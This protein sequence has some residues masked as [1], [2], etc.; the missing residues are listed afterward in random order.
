MADIRDFE[1]LWG[2]WRSTKLLRQGAYGKV[3]LMEKVELGQRYYAAV[4]H[5]SIPDASGKSETLDAG[6]L[7]G[8]DVSLN[9]YY[10]Q[11]VDNH[12]TEINLNYRLKSNNIAS[13]DAHQ[14]ISREQEPGFDI[15][16]KMEFLT[17][18]KSYTMSHAM[19]VR[20]VARLGEDIS[21]ALTVVQQEKVHHWGI[22]QDD[23]FVSKDGVYKL[24]DIGGDK[25]AKGASSFISPE[26]ARGEEGG[27]CAGLYSLGLILYRLMNNNRGPFLPQ[28]AI[29]VTDKMN[30]SAHKRRMEGEALPP[31]ALADE[32]MGRIIL[33][34]CAYE[35][36]DRW[37]SAEQLRDA[38]I[39]YRQSLS[40]EAADAVVLESK[41]KGNATNSTTIALDTEETSVSE[42][43]VSKP[44]SHVEEVEVCVPDDDTIFSA[45]IEEVTAPVLD[46]DTVYSTPIEKVAVSLPAIDTTYSMSADKPTVALPVQ[47]TISQPS[48]VVT[49]SMLRKELATQKPIVEKK[50]KKLWVPIL[51]AVCAL[52]V[53]VVLVLS[54]YTS[55]GGAQ[56]ENVAVSKSPLAARPSVTIRAWQDPV[57][58]AGVR[59]ALGV[60]EGKL[61]PKALAGLEELNLSDS[62]EPISTLMDLAMLPGL[63]RLDLSG[64][65]VKQFDFPDEMAQLTSLNLTG[66]G[67]T[68]LEFMKNPILQGIINLAL[69]NNQV[70]DL[71]P[72]AGLTQL[73]YLNISDTSVLDLT[74][75]SGLPQ[76][77]TISALN[78]SI[79][80]WSP[81]SGLAQVDGRP[82]VIQ[83]PESA[84][85]PTVVVPP[86][87]T[88]PSTPSVT[89][90]PKPTPKPSPTP[91]T[92]AVTSVSLSSSSMLLV[93]GDM[94]TLSAQI[95]PSNA[96][97]QKVTWS[98]SASAVA[99]VDSNGN[100]TAR[101]NGTAIITASCGGQAATCAISIG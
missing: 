34:A 7:A 61:D 53:V 41:Q 84:A 49:F 30:K 43:P 55:G 65:T 85:P 25:A 11:L 69:G 27:Y 58:E 29:R 45:P 56:A 95:S 78:V 21:A 57:I 19:A 96:T 82:A 94:I 6:S 13:Y 50:K 38:L 18:L 93:V 22:K 12:I 87:T 15:L 101:G 74:P 89:P 81:V 99:Q 92:V 48:E 100:V 40:Q 26:A 28:S 2:E 31:P 20:D 72:L 44:L 59:K 79:S 62:V 64:H 60:E 17:S 80:D 35:P 10:Q 71:N 67:C 9:E 33:K 42:E 37:E 3:Y 14:V 16:I 8:D 24:S 32:A 83:P 68:D 51:L 70:L 47:A 1:P 4:K 23:I 52:V 63:K 77:K 39:S 66:C 76:L 5:F 73:E 86:L 36:G 54:S 91:S 97:N 98:S 46:D 88:L 75:L 90:K